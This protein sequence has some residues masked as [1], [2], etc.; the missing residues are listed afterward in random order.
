MIRFPVGLCP[1]VKSHQDSAALLSAVQ[2][3]AYGLT[4]YPQ[5]QSDGDLVPLV[6]TLA[7]KPQQVEN[8][9]RDLFPTTGITY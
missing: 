6:K 9:R 2:N 7:D 1:L 4:R 3:A 8:I 5:F